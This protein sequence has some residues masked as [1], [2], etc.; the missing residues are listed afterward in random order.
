MNTNLFE[1]RVRYSKIDEN[2]KEKRVTE[3]YIVGALSHT[4]A[5]AKINKEMEPYITGEFTVSSIKPSN[6]AEI[7]HEESEGYFHDVKLSFI[8]ID[9]DKGTEKRTTYSMLVVA[10]DLKEAYVLTEA[11]MSDTVS[12]Y[13]IIGIKETKIADYFPYTVEGITEEA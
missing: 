11:K 8:S 9:E 7:I 10:V 5:E 3:Q 13:K 4:E 12:D 6:Y 2:G 1:T